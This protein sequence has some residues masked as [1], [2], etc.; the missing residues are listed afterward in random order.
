MSFPMRVVNS[1]IWFLVLWFL[2]LWVSSVCAVIYII[3]IVFTP[4]FPALD[5][6]AVML[7]KGVNFAHTCSENMV[8]GNHLC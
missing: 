7:L 5:E 2:G 3:V 8:K 1:I 4:C 6:I